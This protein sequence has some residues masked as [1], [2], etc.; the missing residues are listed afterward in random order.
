MENM[1][2]I[3]L[4]F[5]VGAIGTLIGAGGGF[6]LSPVFIFLYPDLTPAVL[7]SMSLLA[8]A[9]NSTSGSIGY[10]F[11]RKVHWPSVALFSIV[12]IPGVLIGVKLTSIIPRH[13]F[14][15]IFGLF[16]V[17]LS[18]F[19]LY[20]SCKKKSDEHTYRFWTKPTMILGSFLSF[21]IGIL[22]SLLGIGGGII[23]VPL[24]SEGLKYP[25]H[26]AAGTSHAILA[27]TSIVAVIGHY[28]AGDYTPFNPMLPFLCIGLVM[29]AQL[30]ASYSKKTSQKI[31]LRVLGLALISV[32]I[33]LV[34]K[35]FA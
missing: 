8:V 2:F 12:G 21:F 20:R 23:H 14:E 10:A 29:G 35:A 30:G 31:I 5:A 7:T 11:R 32:G 3:F 27:I 15:G 6:L 25:L 1:L 13:L 18:V 22:S 17:A 16:M 19:V 4:G 24:L 26:L 33:R 9:A 34:F 28:F